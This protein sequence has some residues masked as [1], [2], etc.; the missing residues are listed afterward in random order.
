[1]NRRIEVL[2]TSA[3][4]LGYRA[5]LLFQSEDEKEKKSGRASRIFFNLKTRLSCVAQAAS[6][7][8]WWF[9]HAHKKVL[10]IIQAGWQP[11]LRKP[12]SESPLVLRIFRFPPAS[13]LAGDAY[14][15]VAAL[16]E[17]D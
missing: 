1:M 5:A 7:L 13:R 11:A 6:L 17:G 2:Q 15:R 4:P 8:V 3:L 14:A 16:R 9:E 10:L 12:T